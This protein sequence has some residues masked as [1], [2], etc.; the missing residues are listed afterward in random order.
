[1]GKHTLSHADRFK[2][3]NGIVFNDADDPND[4][5][6]IPI[7]LLAIESFAAVTTDP[8]AIATT[9]TPAAGGQQDL[10]LDGVLVTAGI[11]TLTAV[12]ALSITAVGNETART[13]TVIGTDANGRPQAEEIAGPNATVTSGVKM[14]AVV[15]RIFVDANTAAA[16]TV[17]E[18]NT[19]PRG[20]RCKSRDLLDFHM[21]TEAGVPVIGGALDPGNNT[22]QTATTADQRAEYTPATGGAALIVMYFPDLTRD[23]AAGAN[24]VDP[25]QSVP[26]AI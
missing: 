3:G 20:L 23:G 4:L 24:F 13:F 6:G 15:T 12:S 11:A 26:S 9:Q 8:D 2:A 5:R 7:A 19:N 1:M 25:S 21:A 22:T 14:F 10:T 17:G 16:V 18:L